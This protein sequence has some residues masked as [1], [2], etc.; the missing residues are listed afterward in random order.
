MGLGLE[1]W[2][3]LSSAS[4]YVASEVQE[5][6]TWFWADFVAPEFEFRLIR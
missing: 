1:E 2:I 3:A 5:P 6:D 4:A